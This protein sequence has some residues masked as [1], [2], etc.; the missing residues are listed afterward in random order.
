M[1]GLVEFQRGR[2]GDAVVAFREAERLRTTDALASYYLGKSLL[3]VG[4]SDDA[5]AAYERALDRKP[6]RADLL[7]VF[8]ALGQIYQRARKTELALKVWDRWEQAF[9]DDL[10]VQEQIAGILA[11]EGDHAGALGRYEK[12]AGKA[13]DPYRK[14]QYQLKAAELKLRLGRGDEALASFETLLGQLKPESWLHRD[15][16]QRIEATFLKTDDYDGLTQYYENWLAKHPDD[17][18]AMGRLGH[19]LGLQGRR[20]EAETWYRKALKAAPSNKTLR[21]ALI[22]QLIQANKFTD[23]A[24]EYAELDRLEPN[25][26]D[27][28]RAWGQLLVEDKSRPEAERKRQ[29]A[30]VWKKLLAAKPKDAV[31]TSQVADLFRQAKLTEEAIELYRQAIVLAPNDPQYR[32]YLGEYLHSLDR[33]PEALAVWKEIATGDKR[34]TKTLVRLAE[35]YRG[36]GYRTE[37]VA[38]MGEACALDPEFTDILRYAEMLRD[39][40]EHDASLAQLDRAAKLAENGDEREQVL[41]ERIKTYVESD[42]LTDEIASL[43][44]IVEPQGTAEQ[45]RTLALLYEAGRK[46]SDA[47]RAIVKALALDDKSLSTWI[48]AARL[49][50]ST[51]QFAEAI[52]AN[53][54]LAALDRRART[55]YLQRIA[56]LS[57][58]LGKVSEALEAGQDVIAAAP[59]NPELYQFYATLC[60]QVGKQNEGLDALRRA[61]RVNPSDSKALLTLAQALADQFRTDEAIELFWRAFDTAEDLDGKNAIVA[62]LTELYLRTNHFDRMIA[63][64]TRLGEEQKNDREATIWLAAAHQAAGDIGTARETLEKLLT[65]ESKDTQLLTQLVRLAELEYDLDQAVAYQRRINELSP[66]RESRQQLAGLLLRSGEIEEA[67]AIWLEL[68]SAIKDPHKVYEAIDDLVKHDR[69]NAALKMSERVLRDNPQDWETLYRQGLSLWKLKR[70][71]EALAKFDQLR[72]LPIPQD[73][74][75]AKVEFQ[76]AQAAKR[77]ASAT[78]AVRTSP[79]PPNYPPALMRGNIGYYLQQTF[80]S[81]DSSSI[82]GGFSGRASAQLWSP[83]N[84]GEARMVPPALRFL[85]AAKGGKAGEAMAALE[86]QAASDAVSTDEL[87]DL[88]TIA[89]FAQRYANQTPSGSVQSLQSPT[90]KILRNL[91]ERDDPGGKLMYLSNL[92]TRGRNVM[93][94]GVVVREGAEPL[95]SEELDHVLACYRSLEASNPEWLDSVGATAILA[96]ELKLAKRDDAAEQA[97]RDAVAR[98]S[99]Y[100]TL[101]SAIQLA[102]SLGKT[103][104]LIPMVEKLEPQLQ[105]QFGSSQSIRRSMWLQL[106]QVFGQK[107]DWDGVMTVIGKSFDARAA[108]IAA[109]PRQRR[110]TSVR[111]TAPMRVSVQIPGS[112]GF[113]SATIEYPQPNSYLDQSSI[114]S[115]YSVFELLKQQQKTNDLIDFVAKRAETSEGESQL[116]CHLA[117]TCFLYWSDRKDE[118]LAKLQEAVELAP[119]DPT[120][121]MQL[122]ELLMKQRKP[123]QALSLLDAFEP[124]EHTVLRDR[125]LLALQAA[126]SLGTSSVPDKAPSGSPGCSSKR[127]SSSNSR[128]PCTNWACTNRPRT[129]WAGCGGGPA[130]RPTPWCR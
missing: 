40:T 89:T 5:A 65:D 72:E 93:R 15:V 52:E 82:Y 99:D 100:R 47:G 33:G 24:T 67:E 74:P 43:E 102:M 119:D 6:T 121:R 69:F 39:A 91:S 13:T 112:T 64:L 97:Y 77:G 12:L 1:I 7:E 29:A 25:N 19:V 31:V 101:Q 118:A 37:A 108:E 49:Y 81:N 115:M 126:V 8:Q 30:E 36:F 85:Q 84:F 107:Q 14:V 38:T 120:L 90:S 62:S 130:T 70:E 44:K 122:A 32:E 51:G 71:D 103:D 21:R 129:C 128:R 73:K 17:L 117:I 116:L 86:Q 92:R 109:Q 16:R 80:D 76:K 58:R 2:D 114:S 83:S 59:G 63:R 54:K 96:Q 4:K 125:E 50:E 94:S 123:E 57:M 20:P 87:W 111:T 9:P 79:Y 106:A 113:R 110:Y 23:A 35:V 127:T 95:P 22:D 61:V 10:R 11:D 104:D 46:S 34:N 68:T 26:P 98:A 45:W 42:R 27:T 28:I 3:L 55:D 41:A 60:F 53:Q 105:A 78:S 56:T 18:D 66:S 88:Y 124:T 48:V 75:S